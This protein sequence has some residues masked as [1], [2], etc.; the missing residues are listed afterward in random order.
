MPWPFFS[1]PIR[2]QSTVRDHIVSSDEIAREL[3]DL[4]RSFIPHLSCSNFESVSIFFFVL[5]GLAHQ[6]IIRMRSTATLE[7]LC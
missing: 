2:L 7:I 6:I 1:N 5:K 4:S 3:P